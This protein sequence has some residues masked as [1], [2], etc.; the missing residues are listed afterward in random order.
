MLWPGQVGWLAHRDLAQSYLGWA[1]YRHAP[2]TWPP[3]ADPAYG[4]GLHSSIYYSDSIPLL[5]LLFKPLSGWLPEPFQYF[6][7]WAAACFVLQAVFAWRLLGLVDRGWLD[8]LLG[9][10]F[11]ALA[12]PML[13]RLGGHMALVG[14]WTILA[15]LWLCLRPTRQGQTGWWSTLV[16]IAMIIHAYLFAMVAALWLAD[17]LQRQC[18]M[19]Q[20]NPL[21]WRGTL[22]RWL[23]ELATVTLSTVLLAWLAGFF[24]VSG[25]GIHADGFGYYRMNVLAPFNGDGWSR[26][27]LNFAQA[28]GE[29]EGFNYLGLGGIGLV[30]VASAMSL[31]RRGESRGRGLVSAPLWT[32]AALLAVLAVTCNVGIGSV[33]WHVPMP[34]RWW[35]KLS[36][37]PL[38]STG[39]L[40]WVTYYLILL[41]S[42]FAVMRT[43][44]G[45][46][47]TA[48]L[49][50]LVMLQLVDLSPGLTGLRAALIA[51]T[52]DTTTSL[53]GPFWTAA[54][55]RYRTLRMLPLRLMAPG[56]ESVAFYAQ[57]HRMRSDAVQLAR[58][59]W[60]TFL[61]LYNHGQ[62]ALLGDHLDPRTLY[63]LDDR[64]VAVARV[65]IPGSSAALFRL[66]GWNVLAPGW[67]S[68]L[69][70]KAV[71]LR[72]LEAAGSP[73]Q[74]PYRSGLAENDTGRQLLG[75]GW[76]SMGP[77]PVS[78]RSDSA[79]VFVPVDGDG[80]PGQ[81][82]HVTL[83]L[84]PSDARR[85][86]PKQ[87]QVWSRGRQV[88]ACAWSSGT[89][90]SLQVALPV[91]RP[92]LHFQPLLLRAAR[93]G[94][95]LRLVL[96]GIRV[97]A[98]DRGT[99]GPSP[100]GP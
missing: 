39:R 3:G 81:V 8:R 48:L 15:A 18:E 94:E 20:S 90:R 55:S 59:D 4:A 69:P 47:R 45:R 21:S 80:Q 31:L 76:N 63:L 93:P 32:V 60:P 12:P 13:N 27:G 10:M 85:S 64:D 37:S 50:F 100:R 86:P 66:D 53:R 36:H 56:W 72:R 26:F 75:E 88:D 40:F 52:S 44:R 96:Q 79:R 30:L 97:A 46:V 89:C 61:S 42:L 16:A 49:M 23:P 35:T 54:G 83:A 1:F 73:F 82:V 43:L 95:P 78:T 87:L 17:M 22:R 6:G 91:S 11:F 70:S 57:S 28:P 33:Q 58:F 92:G 74:L 98:S 99:A 25:T 7:L 5:A 84:E 77:R 2:W 67:T 51:R 24:M 71:N 38:Q 68:G 65:A 19:Q 9:T 62:A 41:A 29:Y 14:Q 34:H